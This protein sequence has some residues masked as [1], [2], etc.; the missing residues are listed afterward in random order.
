MNAVCLAAFMSEL[1]LPCSR[2]LAGF[3]GFVVFKK[4]SMIDKTGHHP[5]L[6]RKTEGEDHRGKDGKSRLRR[7]SEST[8]YI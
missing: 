7:R 1:S 3:N 6:K 8:D 2:Q 5:G 4:K